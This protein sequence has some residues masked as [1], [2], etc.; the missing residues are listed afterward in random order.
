MGVESKEFNINI[1][2]FKRRGLH[3]RHS[4]GTWDLRSISKFA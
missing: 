3:E 4:V 2:E 1:N